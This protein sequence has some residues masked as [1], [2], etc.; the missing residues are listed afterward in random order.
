MSFKPVSGGQPL[1]FCMRNSNTGDIIDIRRDDSSQA[2]KKKIT[3]NQSANS[4]QGWISTQIGNQLFQVREGST[5]GCR[6]ID[7]Q[8][9]RTTQETPM[10]TQRSDFALCGMPAE[11]FAFVVGGYNETGILRSADRFNI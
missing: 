1:I 8:G 4:H 7:Q 5:Q 9:F 10:T 3:R 6:W 11:K 2:G